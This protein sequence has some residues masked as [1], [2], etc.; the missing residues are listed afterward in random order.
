LL[1]A[2][3]SPCCRYHPAGVEY[4][5]SQP[6]TLHAAFTLRLRARPPGLFI[7]GAT[8]TFACAAARR[9]AAILKMALSMGFRSL[10]SRLPA[11]QATR[12][13]ALALAGFISR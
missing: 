12:L 9:L 4:R 7:F 3:L 8:S 1:S 10:V 2:S 6:T 13:L 5:V 11:I